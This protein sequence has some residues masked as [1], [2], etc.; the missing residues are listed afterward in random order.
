MM[1]KADLEWNTPHMSDFQHLTLD[2]LRTH[3]SEKWRIYPP[4]V[5]PLPVAEMD[6]RVAEPIRR[7]I[8][9]MVNKS[10]LG[11]LGSIP[12]LG[13]AFSKFSTSRDGWTPDPAQLRVAADVGVGVV[14]VL[15]VLTSPGDSILIN[16]PVYQ[17][18]YTWVRET[19]LNM[20]DVPMTRGDTEINESEW[21]LDWDG[22]EKAY[23]SGIKVHLLCNPHN[24]LGRVYTRGELD[25]L[26]ALAH[27]YGALIISDEIHSPLTFAEQKF[28]PF[29]SLGDDARAIGVT[30]TSSSKAFNIAG[31]KCAIILTQDTAMHERLNAIAPATHY[32]T[33]FVGAFAS[34]AAFN[35][36]EPWLNELMIQLD[37]N[38]KLLLDLIAEKLPGAR[39]HMP[40]CSYL[41]WIDFSGYKLPVDA[42]THLLE[43]GKVGYSPGINF[44]PT[45]ANFVRLNFAT[46]PSIL[47]EA[48]TRTAHALH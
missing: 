29:L 17:N 30:V 42:A 44:G 24:P 41:Q 6:F 37:I 4:E 12:E 45:S 5:L 26:V 34:V 1:V 11:Y 23:Q 33:S 25:R 18:F 13:D 19:S 7:T 9:E 8:I 32:R 43:Q 46:S 27:K 40:H 21:H 16:S 36:G 14:E 22:I 38:R 3:N 10:D 39:T 35:E 31:L 20:V 47:E 2:E 48:I 15:R 28:T